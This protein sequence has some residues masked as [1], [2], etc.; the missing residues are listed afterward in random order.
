MMT[1]DCRG[2]PIDR[3]F[4]KAEAKTQGFEEEEGSHKERSMDRYRGKRSLTV[5]QHTVG[6]SVRQGS[7][8]PA[9][10]QLPVLDEN[11]DVPRHWGKLVVVVEAAR[12]RGLST[13]P[14]GP[15]YS[16]MAARAP[17]AAI[18]AGLA[19]K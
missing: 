17:A 5:V 3:L 19:T 15:G 1:G 9:I 11:D 13:P 14:K 18:K 4:S 2:L 16:L 10:P 8:S 7:F 12:A 6:C